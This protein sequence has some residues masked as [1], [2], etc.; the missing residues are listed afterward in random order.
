VT[1]AVAIRPQAAGDLD[2]VTLGDAVTSASEI[3]YFLSGSQWPGICV[4]TVRPVARPSN[5][6]MQRW[7]AVIASYNGYW[8]PAIGTWDYDTWAG[9]QP[10]SIP[11]GVAPI[12]NIVRVQIDGVTLDP[13]AYRIDNGRLLTRQDGGIWPVGQNIAVPLGQPGSFSVTV[14]YGG[15]PPQ[16]GID[17]AGIFAIELALASSGSAS[18]LPNGV[19]QV[20]RQGVTETMLDYTKFYQLG[21]TGIPEVDAF[22]MAVNPSGRRFRPR[23]ISPDVVRTRS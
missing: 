23:V 8:A 2:E 14:G 17:A 20:Q 3:L 12:A 15:L 16:A 11:L 19:T 1:A 7:A 5:V 13:S 10:V 9:D 22:I 18:R 21:Y 4:K 6:T